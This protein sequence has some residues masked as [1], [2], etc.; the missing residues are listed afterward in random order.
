VQ[1]ERGCWNRTPWSTSI[2][3]GAPEECH[4]QSPSQMSKD[5]PVS[6]E[7][8]AGSGQSF[9]LTLATRHGRLAK[10][11]SERLRKTYTV[12]NGVR[13]RSDLSRILAVWLGK[14]LGRCRCTRQLD[15]HK[16]RFSQLWGGMA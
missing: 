6:S 10:P 2:R 5:Q 9:L 7:P 11:D 1:E 8:E 4:R 12:S 15:I 3:Q 14:R 13:K 16:S